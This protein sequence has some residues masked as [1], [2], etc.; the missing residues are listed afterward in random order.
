LF[1]G[2]TRAMRELFL[3]E[4]SYRDIHG[5]TLPTIQ[6]QFLGE[7]PSLSRGD[8]EE[9]PET[10]GS[11]ERAPESVLESLPQESAGNSSQRERIE[12]LRKLGG[13]PLLTTGAA[14]LAGKKTSAEVPIGFKIGMRVR[15]PQKGVGEVIEVS[16]DGARRTVGVLFDS[17]E[18]SQFLASKCPLQPVGEG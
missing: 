8:A 14:L 2:M 18:E 6:S 7:V 10:P 16:I 13:K 1:V 5:Q 12:Q 3:T 9:E 4:T 17:G 11:V 15:H